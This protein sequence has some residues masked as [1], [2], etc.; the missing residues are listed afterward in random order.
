ML[1]GP[2]QKRKKRKDVTWPDFWLPDRELD[3]LVAQVMSA[4]QAL[5][6]NDAARAFVNGGT[7]S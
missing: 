6:S 2:W 3:E 7:N 5:R 1:P 4:Y